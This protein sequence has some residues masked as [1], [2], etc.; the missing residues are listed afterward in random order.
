MIK[1]LKKAIEE[2]KLGNPEEFKY[3]V[4]SV[5]EIDTIQWNHIYDL[6]TEKKIL[7]IAQKD[8]YLEGTL[9]YFTQALIKTH[10]K[11]EKLN[12]SKERFAIGVL[13][14][15]Q[16]DF[17]EFIKIYSSK[18]F[19]FYSNQILLNYDSYTLSSL[20]GLYTISPEKFWSSFYS[21]FL[22]KMGLENLSDRQIMNIIKNSNA[23]LDLDFSQ[24]HVVTKAI[25]HLTYPT[26]RAMEEILKYA[27]EFDK[28]ILPLNKLDHFGRNE[29]NIQQVKNIL[30]T[31]NKIK[32]EDKLKKHNLNL[33]ASKKIKL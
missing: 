31:I 1:K 15:E 6:L 22:Y 7:R 3:W 12:L 28:Y 13:S 30:L 9:K 18:I 10:I 8:F 23:C 2:Y 17:K 21:I 29:E 4:K 19:K 33:E 32:L 27:N 20:V 11:C 26:G 16:E 25:E 14:E 24:H 5:K